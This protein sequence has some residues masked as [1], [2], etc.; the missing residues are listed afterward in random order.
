MPISRAFL[1]LMVYPLKSKFH[2]MGDHC[3]R[4]S[5]KVFTTLQSIHTKKE[6]KTDIFIYT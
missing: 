4:L 6:S 2:F 5:H 3:P 1:L